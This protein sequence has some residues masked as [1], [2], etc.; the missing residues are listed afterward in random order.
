MSHLPCLACE[1]Y[2]R[3]AIRLPLPACQPCPGAVWWAGAILSSGKQSHPG[4]QPS[5]RTPSLRA[6]A[7][8]L[9][10]PCVLPACPIPAL[11]LR[12]GPLFA[13]D[14]VPRVVVYYAYEAEVRLTVGWASCV[15]ETVQSLGPGVWP[16]G[17]DAPKRCMHAALAPSCHYAAAFCMRSAGGPTCSP[18]PPARRARA[19]SRGADLLRPACRPRA[20]PPAFL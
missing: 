15:N 16:A 18:A 12:C 4:P 3:A 9:V 13:V 8:L 1:G 17:L 20:P 6:S 7:P 11:D 5:L 10:R 19:S 14:K 2:G